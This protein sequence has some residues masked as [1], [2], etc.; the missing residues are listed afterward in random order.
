M[1]PVLLERNSHGNVGI[2]KK[3]HQN[4][5]DL[6][7]SMRSAGDMRSGSDQRRSLLLHMLQ[8]P[9]RLYSLHQVHSHRVYTS[10]PD[11]TSETDGDGLVAGHPEHVLAVSVADCMPIFLFHAASRNFA[12]LHSGWKGTGIVLRAL[13]VLTTQTDIS[14]ADFTAVL[15]P[16]IRSCCY[17]VDEARAARFSAAWGADSVVWRSSADVHTAGGGRAPYLDLLQANASCLRGAGV[18]DIRYV[19]E[20][21]ACTPDL[22]SFRREGPQRFTH[23]LAMIGYFK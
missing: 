5:P 4:E 20:C 15:G 21:T 1:Q 16:S 6:W 7:L 9:D 18:Q 11:I 17:R 22:G 19:D 2:I 13:D 8:E 23:M 14:A 3:L 12:V 10:G